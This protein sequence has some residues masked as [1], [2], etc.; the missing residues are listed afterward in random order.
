MCAAIN[1]LCK[2]LAAKEYAITRAASY[3][4]ALPLA[5]TDMD[6]DAILMAIDTEDQNLRKD[7]KK[8]LQIIGEWQKDVPLFM[9]ADRENTAKKISLDLMKHSIEFIWIFEDSPTFIA[10][11]II[12]AVERF[13][14]NLLPPLMQAIW[15]YNEENH[16]YSWAAP[17]HQGGRGFVKS[18]SGKKFY[19]FYGEN[20]FRTD[21]G[22]ERS[23]IG[24]LLDHTGAFGKSEKNAA[25]VFGAHVSYSGIV[26]TSGS[27]RSIMQAV[28]TEGDI[29]ICDRNCHKSIEQGLINTG[30][31]PV[32]LKPE[33]NR[34]G[35]IGPIPPAE[36]SQESIA[37][38]IAASPLFNDGDRR[39]YSVVTN[40]TYDGLCYNAAEAEKLLEASCDC[41][42]FDEAWY[43]YARFNPMYH[44]HHAMRG[45]PDAHSG[46]TIF[47]THSTHKLLAALSQAS[48]IHMRNGR[49]KITAD[50]LNQGYL[51][52]AST[53]PLYAICASNDISVKMMADNGEA[54][55]RQVIEEAVDF[56]QAMAKL[57]RDFAAQDSWFFRVWN[58]P[59]VT[60]RA[61]G[62]SYLFAD[63]PAKLLVNDQHCWRL[64][65]GEKW[66]GFEKIKDDN[67]V[68]LDPVK[69]SIIAPGMG[70]DGTILDS[71]VPAAL[72]SSFIYNCGIVPTR[73]TDFQLMFLF[74]IGITRGKW[75]TLLNALLR[76][77]ELYDNN[78]PVSIVLPELAAKYPDKYQNIGIRTLGDQMF[79]HQ[80]HFRPDA[81]LNDAFETLPEQA[82]SPRQAY[83]EMI[84]GNV[85]LIPAAKLAHRIAA[86][87]LIPYP[88]GIPMVISGER[89]GGA[90]NPH[91]AYLQSL[92]AWDAKFPGFEHV[93][94]GS[95]V[96]NGIYHVPCIKE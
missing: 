52:N 95:T 40:C 85:E 7:E 74:S 2:K 91:I 56:R 37:E 43:A 17:G 21:T 61:T 76:F 51:L 70:D 75:V 93:T 26:G 50:Q 78:T 54:L 66:H 63:A 34:Y 53:S 60:D 5:A 9:L 90:D 13:R 92:A 48:F 44:D 62:K 25:R 6:I 38:K 87:A 94:E 83:M 67:W 73:T 82:I 49:K 81:K 45:N 36:M 22:I 39:A 77:K 31:I 46:A 33:R 8:L 79:K 23:S 58:P 20:L 15:K 24:S 86:N 35:I 19:D 10:G 80:K 84:R 28:L 1:A 55:T 64:R 59:E 88:P 89:F 42:H 30:A 18:Q 71:G 14:N 57:E 16:E 12:A 65:P 29:A 68:M 27:N 72:V 4:E 47:A 69:V 11:R 3:S 32:Y 96:I 41:I